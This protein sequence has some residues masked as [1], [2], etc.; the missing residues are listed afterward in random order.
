MLLKKKELLR[1]KNCN[2]IYNIYEEQFKMLQDAAED[3]IVLR[4][5]LDD[6]IDKFKYQD[7]MYK[8]LCDVKQDTHFAESVAV[9]Y[10]NLH[11]D[12]IIASV[13]EWSTLRIAFYK[14]VSCN[15]KMKQII[16]VATTMEVEELKLSK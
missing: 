5:Q 10:A 3:F 16:S 13:R 8:I 14:I 6:K 7:H 1:R 11:Y 9:M 4:R 15:Y 12:N 2:V